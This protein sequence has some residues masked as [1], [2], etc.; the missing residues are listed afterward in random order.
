MLLLDHGDTDE[1]VVAHL[2]EVLSMLTINGNT[3]TK[4]SL[5]GQ[6]KSATPTESDAAVT[7]RSSSLTEDHTSSVIRFRV[8]SKHLTLASRIFKAILRNGFAEGTE[9]NQG[10]QAEVELPSDDPSTF[11]LLFYII[12]GQPGKV[13]S[14][15][16]LEMLTRITILL[17]KYELMR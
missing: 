15:L 13:V 8:S 6:S 12:H 9:L 16:S 5:T 17:D 10:L 7:P 1:A 14:K 11:W 4:R 3:R 2:N